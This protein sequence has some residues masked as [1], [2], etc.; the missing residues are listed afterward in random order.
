MSLKTLTGKPFIL[1]RCYTTACEGGLNGVVTAVSYNA[2]A[3]A[4]TL[5]LSE[6][7]SAIG[8]NQIVLQDINP[9][10]FQ[11]LQTVVGQ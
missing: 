6:V 8:T 9:R 7:N 10:D 1:P 11:F 4:A 2:Q 3:S 5:T